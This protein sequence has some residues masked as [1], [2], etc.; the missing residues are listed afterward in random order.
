MPDPDDALY[1]FRTMVERIDRTRSAPQIAGE[2]A[3]AASMAA[4]QVTSAGIA[5]D[6]LQPID[7]RPC[8]RRWRRRFEALHDIGLEQ[9]SDLIQETAFAS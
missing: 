7:G 2:V 9:A 4:F 8:R 3:P 5:D 1:D 6:D